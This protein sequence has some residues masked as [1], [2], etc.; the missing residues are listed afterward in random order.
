MTR[1]YFSKMA[2]LCEVTSDFTLFFVSS[3]LHRIS[4]IENRRRIPRGI[5]HY[6]SKMAALR[7]IFIVICYLQHAAI[8]LH[9]PLQPHSPHT[10]PQ[11]PHLHPYPANH[12]KHLCILFVLLTP[13][14]SSP[15]RKRASGQLSLT[16]VGRG[17]C[18]GGT[19]QHVQQQ[20]GDPLI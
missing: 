16:T 9:L 20:G 17:V 19:L 2:A 11:H 4:N 15:F 13:Q 10:M 5:S 7:S 12:L 6:F 14:C 3:S 18:G 8:S 1:H